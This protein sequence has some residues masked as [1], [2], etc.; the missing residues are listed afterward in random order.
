MR[1]L[2]LIAVVGALQLQPHAEIT[3][4]PTGEVT[5]T[6]AT[7]EFQASGP[8]P[9]TSFEC[10]LD[11]GAWAACTSP[12]EIK[13]LGGGPHSFE[14]RL[15]GQLADPKA[16]RRDW[17]VRQQTEVVP[18]PLPEPPKPPVPLPPR[19]DKRRDAR[20]CAYGANEVGEVSG[21]RIRRA[22]RCLVNAERAERS[23]R[24][25]ALSAALE[26]A[27]GRHARDMVRR[28]YFSHESPGG[29]H[30]SERVRAT[31][32]LR[33]AQYWTVGE[34]LAWLVR[35]RPTPVA[36][37]DAWMHSKPHKAVLLHPSFRQVGAAFARGNP[38]I[39]GNAG[40]TFAAVFGRKT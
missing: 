7:F 3:A 2:I 27:A 29:K 10:R 14:V 23:L 13:S 37:V 5:A 19:A 30:V 15:E 4:G 8:A 16:D 18:P 11:A 32:Y 34:V 39:R 26:R 6:A 1:G 38:R 20:G 40:A 17:T 25:V 31:G 35:P 28:R 12:H 24:P 22:V 36:V 9:L 21:A 33:G